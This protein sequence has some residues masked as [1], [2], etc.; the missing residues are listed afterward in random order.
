M[1]T[2]SILTRDEILR[3]SRH[4]ILPE[5]GMSGQERLKSSRVLIVGAGGLGSPVAMYLA[6]A[7]VG[8]LGLVDFDTVDISNL[9]RQILHS[10]SR[11]GQSKL[12]SARERLQ[13]INS[14]IQLNLHQGKLTS[15]N[16]KNIFQEYDIIIDGTDNF[17]TRY[18]INDASVFMGK[19]F[20]YGS[21]YR[22]SGQVTVFDVSRGPCYR[23]VYPEPPPP[24]LV[25]SCAEGG[26]L[27]V[28]PGIIGT[29]QAIE[30]IK[31]LLEIGDPLYGRLLMVDAL[32][33][34]F[35]EI[36]IPPNP[37][38]PLCGETPTINEFI[39]YEEFCGVPQT[40]NEQHEDEMTVHEL[41]QLIDSGKQP[42]IIDVREPVEFEICRIPG[43]TLI[44]LN[45]LPAMIHQL[46]T[47]E[48]IVVYCHVGIRSR[49][50]VNFLREMGFTRVK[51]LSGGIHAWATQIDPDMPVY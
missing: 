32:S 27:G 4:L 6:A 3:Y 1:N 8:T 43:A 41:R 37:G 48:D 28:L 12:E 38:C 51:N 5:V 46:H 15:S 39:D 40:D 19:P 47:A 9:Q 2:N 7:G 22:F 44:P 14:H 29:L 36:A 17:P 26:V 49:R 11:V 23:C 50:A 18:L 45:E 42:T 20:I 34:K 33:M 25:P 13:E 24:E 35:H 10:E 16:V 21:I 31:I 30:A